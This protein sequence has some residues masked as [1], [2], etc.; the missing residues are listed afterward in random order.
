MSKSSL[1]QLVLFNFVELRNAVPNQ[2]RLVKVFLRNNGALSQVL[3]HGRT[4]Y[5]PV[6]PSKLPLESR[7]P[8]KVLSL[9]IC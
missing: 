5:F 9:P 6:H 3:S 2:I 8:F 1:S 7:D 4:S